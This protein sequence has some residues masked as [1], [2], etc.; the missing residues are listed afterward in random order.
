MFFFNK[1]T[2]AQ[3]FKSGFF[4]FLLALP[5][6]L[7]IS[8]ASGFPPVGGIFTAVIG[9][10]IASFLGSS[11]LTIKG[12]AAGLI[13]IVI[14]AVTELGMGDPILGYKRTLAVG[15]IA[16]VLQIIFGFSKAG[17][18]GEIIPKSVVHGMLSAIGVIIIAK[19]C[20][21]LL[22]VVPTAKSPLGL[23]GE[24]P[25]HILGLNPEVFLI[26]AMTLALLVFWPKIAP[27][28]S[29]TI[30]AAILAL[31]FS[32]ILGVVFNFN[33]EHDY[34]F[35]N[36]SYHIDTKQLINLP[37]SFFGAFAFPD[38]SVIT[39][40][41]SIKYIVMLS[42]VGSIE[43][44]LTVNAVDSMDP[45]KKTS[46]L[47]KDLIATGAGNLLASLVGGL[48]MI[49]EIVR[50]KANVDNG[51]KTAQSNF[52]HGC[53]LLISV[54][55][56]PNILHMIPATT[57]A[58]MLVFTGFRLASP[59]EFSHTYKIGMDQFAPFMITFIVTLAIDLLVGVIAG[60]VAQLVINLY[61]GLSFS[62]LFSVRHESTKN[63][64]ELK[65]KVFSPIGFTNSY[66]LKKTLEEKIPENS[67]IVV[68]FSESKM[69]EHSCFQ[70]I[71]SLSKNHDKVLIE[72]TGLHGHDSTS[73]HHH[74][75]KIRRKLA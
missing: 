33:Q 51:A 41:L 34:Q 28:L 26:A 67:K 49:S 32:M 12:P 39:S 42:L 56:F 38:F 8:I 21:L 43:S 59:N 45:E 65:I 71:E 31:A 15:V 4:V 18:I 29:K 55:L 72:M 61:H 68:D 57:L 30:P 10:I 13:V 63:N 16:A 70:V 25:T 37:A 47:N 1:D 6:C 52:F 73:G 69:V 64:G 48:P 60:V 66:Q 17:I 24:F 14:G 54:A 5:L 75:T 22:G 46:D 3:D 27:K 20:H 40:F 23:L 58:A 53:L 7:G 19:Q 11:R 9:G 36:F 74:A 35:L 2:V 50:S 62:D 44:L